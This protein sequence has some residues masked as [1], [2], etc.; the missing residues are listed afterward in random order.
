MKTK[1]KEVQWVRGTWPTHWVTS[2]VAHDG[3]RYCGEVYHR[4]DLDAYVGELH[5]H[6]DDKNDAKCGDRHNEL[7]IR[8]EFASCDA[9]RYQ[10]AGAFEVVLHNRERDEQPEPDR[11]V[12]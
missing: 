8:Y 7:L 11:R 12:S 9:A 1:L 6:R 10:I 4:A 2:I 3:T 5:V